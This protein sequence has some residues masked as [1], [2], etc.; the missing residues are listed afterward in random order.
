MPESLETGLILMA[1]GMG[2]VYVLLAL[3]VWLVGLVSKLSRWLE[4][5]S[6]VAPAAATPTGAPRTVNDGEL[7][8]VISAAIQAHRA[9]QPRR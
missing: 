5:P 1:A 9:R 6:A 4:P 2:M 8:G 3:L 7:V